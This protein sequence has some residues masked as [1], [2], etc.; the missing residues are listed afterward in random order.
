MMQILVASSS[1]YRQTTYREMIETFGHR[2]SCAN[3]GIECIERLRQGRFDLLILEAPLLWGGSDGVLDV[4][5]NGGRGRELPVI[6]VAVGAGPIDWL[7]L[8]RFR[9]DDF[10]FRLPTPLDLGRAVAVIA[11]RLGKS[12]KAPRSPEEASIA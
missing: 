6:L 12:Q 7:Q 4:V 1:A 2:V 10:L 8:G 11:T 3:S 9:I 5:Q